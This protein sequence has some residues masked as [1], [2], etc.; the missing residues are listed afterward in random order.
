METAAMEVRVATATAVL[1]ARV[2]MAARAER[3][4]RL[5]TAEPVG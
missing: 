2:K 1:P 5:E 4:A 3:P